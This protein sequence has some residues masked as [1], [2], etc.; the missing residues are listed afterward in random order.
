MK[1]TELDGQKLGQV[2]LLAPLYAINHK[3]STIKEAI[4]DMN[5]KPEDSSELEYVKDL[6]TLDSDEIADKWFEGNKNIVGIFFE[7]K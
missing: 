5:S 4:L 2:L 1:F 7:D 3:H 6:F